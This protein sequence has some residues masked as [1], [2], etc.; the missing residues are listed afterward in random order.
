M[1]SISSEVWCVFYIL[2]CV[3]RRPFLNCVLQQ[4]QRPDRNFNFPWRNSFDQE[5]IS[6]FNVCGIIEST[7]WDQIWITQTIDWRR[8]EFTWRRFKVPVR[9]INRWVQ[10][11]SFTYVECLFGFH[12]AYI[13]SPPF[14][15]LHLLLHLFYT[16]LVAWS[17]ELLYHNPPTGTYCS[18]Y[19]LMICVG[20]CLSPAAYA[21]DS[22]HLLRSCCAHI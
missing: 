20:R 22:T 5:S 4:Q 9:V 8:K 19:I 2:H 7:C 10:L 12:Y 17:K 1:E 21:Q 18:A 14:L 3:Q 13:F 11:Q 16:L 15:L 6:A